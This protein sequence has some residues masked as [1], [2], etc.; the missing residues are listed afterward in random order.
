MSTNSISISGTTTGETSPF[1]SPE[2][3][4]CIEFELFTEEWG[5]DRQGQSHP[6]IVPVRLLDPIRIPPGSRVLVEGRLHRWSVGEKLNPRRA[7]R[8]VLADK[9][10]ILEESDERATTR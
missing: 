10:T 1:I 2:Y 7:V 3:G 6:L 9:A 8:G 4:H 5:D